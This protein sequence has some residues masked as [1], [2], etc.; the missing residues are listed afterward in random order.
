M[1]K[2]QL[3]LADSGNA[4]NRFVCWPMATPLT[5]VVV[6]KPFL[7]ETTLV[8]SRFSIRNFFLHTW[9]VGEQSEMVP[10]A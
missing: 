10:T 9:K 4:S 3:T 5:H 8:P 1:G 2:P 6:V 7:R